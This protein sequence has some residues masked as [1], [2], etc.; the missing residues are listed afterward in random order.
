MAAYCLAN[1]EIKDAE[2]LKEYME[3]APKIFKQFGGKFLVRGGEFEVREGNWNPKRL[4]L[5]EFESMEQAK[6][7]YDSEEYQGIIKKR[8]LASYTEWVIIQGVSHKMS[9]MLND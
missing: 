6:A 3:F 1:I 8:K 5:V 4:I 9:K 7:F 2:K